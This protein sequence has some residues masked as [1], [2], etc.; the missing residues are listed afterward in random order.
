MIERPGLLGRSPYTPGAPALAAGVRPLSKVVREVTGSGIVVC[1][2]PHEADPGE[3]R[4]EG[5]GIVF[6]PMPGPV[7][8]GA[9]SLQMPDNAP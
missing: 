1:C 7:S 3:Q 5:H 9:F 6:E 2:Q 4:C 8:S